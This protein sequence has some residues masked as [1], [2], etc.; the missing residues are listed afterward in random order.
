MCQ[1]NIGD[2]DIIKFFYSV[3]ERNLVC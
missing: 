1:E 3:A 2:G